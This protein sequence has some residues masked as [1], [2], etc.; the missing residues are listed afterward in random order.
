MYYGYL[1]VTTYR[2]PELRQVSDL[3]YERIQCLIFASSAPGEFPLPAPR[4]P[5]VTAFDVRRDV[6]KA[7]AIISEVQRDL[8]NTQAIVRDMMKG[9]QETGGQDRS[10][11]DTCALLATG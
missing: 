4:N 7:G 10:V 8:A 6:V 5:H 1:G 3:N 11:S 9:Q 2:R